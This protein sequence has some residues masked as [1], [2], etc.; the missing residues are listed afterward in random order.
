MRGRNTYAREQ[1]IQDPVPSVFIVLKLNFIQKI[2]LELSSSGIIIN[3]TSSVD[4][5]HSFIWRLA[6]YVSSARSRNNRMQTNKLHIH[7]GALHLLL[8]HGASNAH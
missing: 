6:E 7:G 2:A 3:E 5:G 1:K 4:G 8:L